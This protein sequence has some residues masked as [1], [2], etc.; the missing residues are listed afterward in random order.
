[1]EEHCPFHI[2]GAENPGPWVITADHARNTVP[3]W[4]N[5]GCLGLS[6]HDMSRH[7]AFDIGAEGVARQL[8]ILLNSPVIAS[9]FSRLVIDPNRGLDDPTLIMK[10]YDGTIIDAN[11]PMTEDD[12]NRRINELYQPYHAAFGRL[13][14][15]RPNPVILAIHSFTPQLKDRP[16]RPW[17]VGV[18]HAHDTRLS[19]PLVQTLQADSDVIVGVNEPYSGELPGDSVDR[20][21]LQHGHLNILIEI[22][23]DLIE[24]EAGQRKWAE[25]LAPIFTNVLSDIRGV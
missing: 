2:F 3:T 22:R 11:H 7:I 20:H 8:G 25:K 1:M 4:V 17:H 5:G 24:T 13:V 12:R 6:E 9:N 10:L 21:A 16:L 15:S 18:L 19:D 23:N 14:K